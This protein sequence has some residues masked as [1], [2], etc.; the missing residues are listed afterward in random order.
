MPSAT[1]SAALSWKSFSTGGIMGLWPTQADENVF[2]PAT[3]FY[4]S[5]T[6]PFVIPTEA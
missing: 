5:T 4:E 1:S 6:L 3:A 2:C